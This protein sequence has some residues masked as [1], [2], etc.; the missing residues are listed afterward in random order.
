MHV[1]RQGAP[2]WLLFGWQMDL[3]CVVQATSNTIVVEPEAC[4]TPE[5]LASGAFAEQ[6]QSPNATQVNLTFE[7]FSK[8]TLDSL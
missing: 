3:T 5:T 1:P 7:L 6:P 8:F 4:T 2:E